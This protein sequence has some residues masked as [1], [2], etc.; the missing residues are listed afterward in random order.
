[1]LYAQVESER[2]A[3][4]SANASANHA[5]LQTMRTFLPPDIWS[6]TQ[7]ALLEAGLTEPLAKRLWKTKVRLHTSKARL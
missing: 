5:A 2:L 7:A 4:L 1:M 6:T 3:W